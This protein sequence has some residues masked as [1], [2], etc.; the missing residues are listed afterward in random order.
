VDADRSDHAQPGDNS[1]TRT[2][3]CGET[4][5]TPKP[6]S[7]ARWSDETTADHATTSIPAPTVSSCLGPAH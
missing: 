4:L 5:I 3:G 6:P 1:P 7:D 2:N